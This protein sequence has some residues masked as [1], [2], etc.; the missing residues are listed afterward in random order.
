MQYAIRSIRAAQVGTVAFY[1]L[2]EQLFGMI[3]RRPPRLHSQMQENKVLTAVGVYALDVVAQTFK[4]INAFEITY[5]GHVVHSKLDSGRF[6]APGELV[7]R[8]Q[9]LMLS[10]SASQ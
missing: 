3:G 10:E 8:M 4:S 9:Q 6:P 2:G 7:S 1:F 5:N